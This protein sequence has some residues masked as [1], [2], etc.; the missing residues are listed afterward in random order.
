MN[1]NK[2]NIVLL[3][4]ILGLISWVGCSSLSNSKAEMELQKESESFQEETIQPEDL[5][6]EIEPPE[7]EEDSIEFEIIDIPFCIEQAAEYIAEM[8]AIWDE[9]DGELWGMYLHAPVMIICRNTREIITNV[10]DNEGSLVPVETEFGIVYSG[11]YPKNYFLGNTIVHWNDTWWGMSIWQDL[12]NSWGG[13]YIMAHEAFHVVQWMEW[14]IKSI[15]PLKHIYQNKDGEVESVRGEVHALYRALNSTGDERNEA[16]REVLLYRTLRQEKLEHLELGNLLLNSEFNNEITEG[17]AMYTAFKLVYHD[18]DEIDK[19][20]TSFITA[21][22]R[23]NVRFAGPDFLFG[24]ISGALYAFL[25][26]DLGINWKEGITIQTNLAVFL[27]E[28]LLQ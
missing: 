9:D 22:E 2:K 10:P 16:I 1:M 8:T 26:D 14:S 13:L 18:W 23:E 28:F 4:I 21:L 19:L 24:Y 11:F 20:L 7:Q 3:I 15:A 27:E 25:L 6:T 17:M 5:K 12:I